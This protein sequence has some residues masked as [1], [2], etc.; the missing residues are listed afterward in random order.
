MTDRQNLLNVAQ[1]FHG[2]DR[3]YLKHI[4]LF[5]TKPEIQAA[6]YEAIEKQGGRNADK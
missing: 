3:E 6:L 1:D 2:K 5:G 4:A